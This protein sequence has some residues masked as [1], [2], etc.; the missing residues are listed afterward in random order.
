MIKYRNRSSPNE[1]FIVNNQGK[2]ERLFL[3]K[4]LENFVT[5]RKTRE[6][7]FGE[8]IITVDRSRCFKTEQ[9]AI[10]SIENKNI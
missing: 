7:K 8:H 10:K 6:P 5:L 1:R 3:V 4:E 9:E 2:V